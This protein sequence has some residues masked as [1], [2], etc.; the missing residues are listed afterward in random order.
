V[1]IPV[2]A[3][4][5]YQEGTFL[6]KSALKDALFQIM[7]QTGADVRVRFVNDKIYSPPLVGLDTPSDSCVDIIGTYEQIQR[8]KLQV[9]AL[10]GQQVILWLLS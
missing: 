6:V 2:S 8:A 5:V 1:S 3:C 10:L 7:E 4:T 9:M